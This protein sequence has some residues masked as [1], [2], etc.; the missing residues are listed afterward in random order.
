MFGYICRSPLAET[1]L[2]DTGITDIQADT[3]PESYLTRD[4]GRRPNSITDKHRA[5]LLSDADFENFDM[6]ISQRQR[7]EAPNQQNALRAFINSWISCLRRVNT[8]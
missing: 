3:L 4:L 6:I 7:E 2:G 8:W 5:R 1:S